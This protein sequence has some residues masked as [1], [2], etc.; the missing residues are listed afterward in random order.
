MSNASLPPGASSPREHGRDDDRER[1]RSRA[2][3][4]G[5]GREA[6]SDRR[7]DR[8][9]ERDGP[10]ARQAAIGASS[11]TMALILHALTFVCCMNWL[12]GVAGIVFAVRAAHARDR[13]R[14]VQ[15]ETLTRYS[16]YCLGA[17]GVMLFVMLVL[18]LVMFTQAGS[19]IQGIVPVT[20]Y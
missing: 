7:D 9:D 10:D 8:E 1:R 6:G 4:R 19:W 20:N 3:G 14:A 13:G 11:S 12:F 16:W 17:A 2:P 18:T 15:A 5:G